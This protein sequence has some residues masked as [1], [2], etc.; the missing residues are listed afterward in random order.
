VKYQRS[1]LTDPVM[2]VCHG[3]ERIWADYAAADTRLYHA[4]FRDG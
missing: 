3:T 4:A 2:Y 1:T